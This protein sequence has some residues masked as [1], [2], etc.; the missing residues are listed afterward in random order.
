[1]PHG[2]PLWQLRL[3][4]ETGVDT[5]RDVRD[6]MTTKKLA[7]LFIA[8]GVLV[9]CTK[10]EEGETTTTIG[11]TMTTLGGTE[12]TGGGNEET[13]NGSA[14]S[15]TT[16]AT[17]MSDSSGGA[18]EESSGGGGGCTDQDE[19]M[20]DSD[21]GAGES[22]LMPGCTCFGGAEESS[23]GGNPTMSDY[24]PC[25]ACGPGE[26]PVG[27][28]DIE[29]CFC[30]PGCDGQGSMCATPNEGTAQAMCVLELMMGAGPTQCALICDPAMMGMC[31]TGATCTEV[32][33]GVGICLHP[34]P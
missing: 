30:S 19:C 7:S 27:L 12:S 18:V 6:D 3:Q 8:A 23:G 33:P 20:S 24:G 11:T 2:C 26:M 14:T 29:G 17:T 4:F 22:C 13:T 16:S 15:E 32:Q 21:C 1:L 25:D 5:H 34:S 9:G 31:P 28:M 10:D